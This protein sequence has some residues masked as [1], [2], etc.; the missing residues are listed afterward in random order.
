MLAA[1]GV[2]DGLEEV[3][4]GAA[5]HAAE[6]LGEDGSDHVSVPV[7]EERELVGFFVEV[8]AG[9]EEGG[10]FTERAAGFAAF[11]DSDDPDDESEDE[12]DEE[13]FDRAAGE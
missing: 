5:V 8:S 12:E 4:G 3:V 1:D 9:V 6:A 10:S 13:D 7:V 11:E 2:G